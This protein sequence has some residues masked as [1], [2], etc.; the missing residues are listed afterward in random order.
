MEIFC[1]ICLIHER[2][3]NKMSGPR[4]LRFRSGPR[5]EKGDFVYSCDSGRDR[6]YEQHHGYFNLSGTGDLIAED[7]ASP[8]CQCYDV[9]VMYIAGLQ[10]DGTIL[11]RCPSCSREA[12]RPIW[13][14]RTLL[15]RALSRNA[16]RLGDEK[17]QPTARAIA[18][19][20]SVQ[21][22]PEMKEI[23]RQDI[24]DR[25]EPARQPEVSNGVERRVIANLAYLLWQ[26]RCCPEGSPEEDWFEAE[27]MIRTMGR[28][29]PYK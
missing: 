12:I 11:Y 14:S 17:A 10:E 7:P 29:V 27:E 9:V 13:E 8:L 1:D 4:A 26:G 18:V 16:S 24:A 28:T 22:K 3:I 21:G 5:F 20:G 15:E 25:G 23:P 6:Y 2:E 19:F